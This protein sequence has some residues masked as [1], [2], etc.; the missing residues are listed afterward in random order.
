MSPG[1]KKSNPDTNFL[2]PSKVPVNETPPCSPT[3]PLW[4]ELPVYRAFFTSLKLAIKIFLNKEIFS[5][6]SKAPGKERPSMFLK[7]RATMETDSH[8]QNFT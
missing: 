4:R 3:G 8:F 1:S 7:R 2:L 5:L 6:L